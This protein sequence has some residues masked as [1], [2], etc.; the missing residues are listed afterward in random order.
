MSSNIKEYD[1]QL[2]YINLLCENR[3]TFLQN[4]SAYKGTSYNIPEKLLFIVRKT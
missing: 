4:A 2:T 1:G 3:V